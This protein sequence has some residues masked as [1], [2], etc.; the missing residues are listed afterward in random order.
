MGYIETSHFFRYIEHQYLRD[1]FDDVYPSACIEFHEQMCQLMTHLANCDMH[2]PQSSMLNPAVIP[3]RS[4]LCFPQ[5]D[6]NVKAAD[7]R[8]MVR[9]RKRLASNTDYQR[10]QLLSEGSVLCEDYEDEP[11]T[12]LRGEGGAFHWDVNW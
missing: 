9:A 1:V 3:L 10:E 6:A 4:R 11:S 8:L 12:D 2:L 7:V 5:H